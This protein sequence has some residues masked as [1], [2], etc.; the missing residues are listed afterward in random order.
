MTTVPQAPPTVADPVTEDLHGHTVVDPYRWLEDG[1]D[2]AVVAWVKEQNRY[3]RALLDAVPFRAV[4]EREL[5]GLLAAGT[6]TPPEC[7]AGRYFYTRRVGS[8][9]Q[10]VLCMREG[11][12]GTDRTLFDPNTLSAEGRV[13]LDWWYPSAD[14]RLLAFGCSLD[15]DE[16][17]TL[18]ILEVDTG[19]VLPERIGRMRFASVAWL[20]DSSGFYY[21]RY[22]EVG[23]VPPGEEEYHARL[24]FHRVGTLPTADQ[25]VSGIEYAREAFVRVDVSSDGRYAVVTVNH[26]WVRADVYAR[27]FD[28]VE[29]SFTPLVTGYDALFNCDIADGMLYLHTNLDAPRYHLYA[30]DIR[31]PARDGWREIIGEPGSGV[32][33]GVRLAGHRLVATY[34]RHA[35]SAL[36]IHRADGSLVAE[37]TLPAA[38]T[39][40]GVTGRWD[41][42]EAF[43]AF[44]SFVITPA[45]YQL[46]LADGASRPWIQ[47]EPQLD[48]A[49]YEIKQELYR[50]RDGTP[51]SMF[52]VHSAG[53]DRSRPHPL[54]LTAYGGFGASETP[55]FNRLGTPGMLVWL[56]HGGIFALPNLRGGGEYGEEWHRAGKLQKKQDVF[57]DFIAAA[58]Y[59]IDRGYT[60]SSQLG[61]AG[62][63][64]GGLL[65]GAALTQ[66]PELFRAAVCSVPLLDM[67]RYHRFHIAQAWIP[68]YGSADNAD[69]FP[70][71]YAYSPYHHIQEGTSYPA[72]LF[73][74]GDSDT[75]VDPSHARKMAARLQAASAGPHPIL[76]HTESHAGHGAGKPLAKLI[77][78]GAD[79]WSFLFWQLGLPR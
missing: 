32:L 49:R 16:W 9:N 36:A 74:T 33:E 13:S 28:D 43:Y 7:R 61:I 20:P 56:A 47:S 24:F 35:A 62:A 22:P 73:Q 5:A 78:E 57:D 58:E 17:S 45:V 40:T 25:P 48:P 1:D 30:A 54:L 75:R 69:Q 2:P 3:A 52:V 55:L 53:L 11:E 68:E 10:A 51:V 79:L 72:I 38:G 77:A 12:A 70:F 4:I 8:Q 41:E 27:R 26:G 6:V 63:S 44:E 64:N 21:T 59:L 60:D 42:A 34:L 66:R 46:S 31:R 37:V 14:G 39:V 23:E 76:L 67:L 50:S 15:D 18:Q 65:V 19:E 29:A 71:L